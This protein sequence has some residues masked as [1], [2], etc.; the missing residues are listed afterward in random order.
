MDKTNFYVTMQVP[1]KVR[2]LVSAETV[3]DAMRQAVDT[4]NHHGVD[5]YVSHFRLLK[6]KDITKVEEAVIRHD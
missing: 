5:T 1:C 4:I 2:V 6:E 3:P